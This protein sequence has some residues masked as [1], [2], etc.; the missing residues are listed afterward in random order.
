MKTTLVLDDTVVR[1]L[2]ERAAQ[3]RVTMSALV[4]TAL[5]RLLDEPDQSAVLRPLPLFKNRR[6]LVDVADRES[7]YD[8][9]E[10]D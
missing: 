3:D 6:L 4:E 10:R 8:A 7:L 2:K 9:M 1:R 5:R